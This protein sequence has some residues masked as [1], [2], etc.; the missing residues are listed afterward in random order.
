MEGKTK[1]TQLAARRQSLIHYTNWVCHRVT[2][3]IRFI[4]HHQSQQLQLSKLFNL[5]SML[6]TMNSSNRPLV[7]PHAGPGWHHHHS[8]TGK[9]CSGHEM[10]LPSD[11]ITCLHTSHHTDG[12]AIAADTLSKY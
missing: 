9:T 8:P 3:L 6:Q 1:S 7:R 11:P 10:P 2:S 12:K 4:S 5:Y